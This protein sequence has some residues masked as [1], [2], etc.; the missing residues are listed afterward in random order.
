MRSLQK[1]LPLAIGL[2]MT[3][4]QAAGI[5][6]NGLNGATDPTVGSVSFYAG[7]PATASDTYVADFFTPGNDYLMSGLVGIAGYDAFIGVSKAGTKFGQVSFNIASEYQFPASGGDTTLMAEAYL[8]GSLVG[9][10]SVVV[11][12]TG[13]HQLLLSFAGGFD[14]LRIFDDL[15]GSG[16]GEA[17]HIDDFVYQDYTNPPGPG[18]VPEPGTLLLAALGLGG[19]LAARRRR[20]V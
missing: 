5:D 18:T 14:G 3:G 10:R 11:S 12:D 15:N 16:L 8:G 6:F 1:A 7:D 9:T 19:L 20:T 13:Y 4:A 2:L 17:F